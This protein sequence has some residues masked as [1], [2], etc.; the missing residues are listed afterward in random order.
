[1]AIK[2]DAT[3]DDDP[4]VEAVKDH[5]D[6]VGLPTVLLFDSA[7]NE[8]VRCTDFVPADTFLKVLQRVD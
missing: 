4:A 5:L 1:V 3:N 6:V 2:V 8:A 7:G